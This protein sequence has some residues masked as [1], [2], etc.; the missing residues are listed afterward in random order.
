MVSKGNI[1]H[2]EK[3]MCEQLKQYSIVLEKRV[4]R[5]DTAFDHCLESVPDQ[6]LESGRNSSEAFLCSSEFI[7]LK[8]N[9]AQL[10]IRINLLNLKVG[11]ISPWRPY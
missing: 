2:F 3:R 10:E 7:V 4:D 5:Y 11:H 8:K 9:I 6:S 1:L